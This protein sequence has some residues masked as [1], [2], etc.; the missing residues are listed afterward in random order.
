MPLV[1]LDDL[2]DDLGITRGLGEEMMA[3]LGE[4]EKSVLGLIIQSGEITDDEICARL[5]LAPERINGILTVLE[6]K[7]IIC[8]AL[9]KI[10]L[11]K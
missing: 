9:G 7:G 11:A 1:I 2:L 10:F 4:D 5:P 6:M 8:S 3:G